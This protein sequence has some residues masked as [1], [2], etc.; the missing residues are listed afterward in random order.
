[1]ESPKEVLTI[2]QD[3]VRRTTG[4]KLTTNIIA[5]FIINTNFVSEI[6]ILK[7]SYIYICI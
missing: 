6:Y 1:M 4:A 3:A 2:R 7:I 5:E